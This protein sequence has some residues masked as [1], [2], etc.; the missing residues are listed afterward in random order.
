[1]RSATASTAW[2]SWLPPIVWAGVLFALSSGSGPAFAPPYPHIDKLEH[3]GAYSVLGFLVARA[4]HRT[5]SPAAMATVLTGGLVAAA[6]GASD[7]FHQ[8]FTPGRM[9]EVADAIADTV[10]GFAGAIAFVMLSRRL[11][12]KAAANG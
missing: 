4:T 3:A 7:E 8:S 9:V 12:L 5:W 1:V 6:Y 11:A 10:G 2:I